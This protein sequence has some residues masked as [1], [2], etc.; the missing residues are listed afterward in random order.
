MATAH[1]TDGSHATARGGKSRVRDP[2]HLGL[3][4]EL[5]AIEA[6][7]EGQGSAASAT[8]A[9]LRSSLSQTLGKAFDLSLVLRRA[10]A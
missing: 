3:R 9:W 8:G 2:Q 10:Q 1:T 6:V 5:H 4:E 7:I